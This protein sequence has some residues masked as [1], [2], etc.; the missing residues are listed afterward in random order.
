[1]KKPILITVLVVAA[2]AIGGSAYWFS[3]GG[4]GDPDNL[5]GT[6]EGDS[7]GTTVILKVWDDKTF[8]YQGSCRGQVEGELGGFLFDT[9]SAGCVDF[10][11]KLIDSG[12]SIRI[13]NLTLK[14]SIF[15]PPS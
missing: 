13:G 3:V 1:M 6:W 4:I 5:V 7:R 14:K 15:G 8:M 10:S 2:V 12:K 11:G 9:H